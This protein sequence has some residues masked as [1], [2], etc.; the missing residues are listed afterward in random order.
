M[1][2]FVGKQ[3]YSDGIKSIKNSLKQKNA[4]SYD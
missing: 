4:D 3:N 1:N 2:N